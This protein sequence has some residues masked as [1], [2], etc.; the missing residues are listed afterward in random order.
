MREMSDGGE[1]LAEL[2]ARLAKLADQVRSELPTRARALREALARVPAN[3][4]DE[5]RAI[6]R[7]AHMV[8]GTA[9]SHGMPELTTPATEVETSAP[10]ASLEELTRSVHALADAIDRTAAARPAPAPAPVRAAAP[11]TGTIAKPLVGRRVLAIDDDGPTRRLL[12]MTLAN[13]GGATA[14]VEEMP[15][16]FFAALEG[17]RYDAVIVDAM[18][19]EVNGLA[20]LQRIAGSPLAHE[21]TCYFVL[22]AATC[23]ELRWELPT[24][25]RIGW[26]RKPF[27]PAELLAAIVA[28][29]VRGADP[30]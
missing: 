29:V 2:E 25:L 8:R 17:E 12:A 6:Q 4:T 5:R 20:C 3:E 21:G 27:R 7:L 1:K 23:E 13:L 28:G 14:V 19:P 22:S 26:L 24:T 16:A 10:S 11:S 15:N 9:G 18:M 30:T